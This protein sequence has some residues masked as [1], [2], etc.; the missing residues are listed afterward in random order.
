MSKKI[1]D[2]VAAIKAG[3]CVLVLGPEICQIDYNRFVKDDA[4]QNIPK[5][6]DES[7]KIAYHHY[8]RHEIN[9][10]DLEYWQ[11]RVK[12]VDYPFIKEQLI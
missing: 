1:Q 5:D 2:I 10:D 12:F 4:I 9:A 6:F 7:L 8:I 11:E 3:R